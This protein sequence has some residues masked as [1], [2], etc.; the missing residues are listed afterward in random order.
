[1][2]FLGLIAK[3]IGRNLIR[4]ILTALGTMMLVFVVTLV[5]SILS[6]LNVA[7]SEKNANFKA[8]IT[9]RWQI[10]SQMPYTYAATLSEGAATKPDD[11]R[12]M[13]SMT[14]QFYGGSIEKDRAKRGMSNIVFAFSIE[15]KK[16]NTMMDELDNLPPQTA[17]S[18]AKTVK[19]LE[20]NRQGMILGKTRM[21]LLNKKVGDTFTIYSMNYKDIDLEVTVVGEFPDGRYNN[22]GAINKDYLLAAMDAWQRKNGKPHVMAAKSLNLVWLKVPN[23]ATLGQITSQIDGS[24]LFKSPEVKCETAS[25]GIAAFIEPYRD[26]IW[27]MRWLLAPAILVTLSLVISNSISISVRER[28]TELAVLKVLGFRPN[29]ILML[30]LGEAVLI[31]ALSGLIS[32]GLTYGIVNFPQPYGFGGIKFPIA[33]FAAFLIPLDALWWGPALGAGTAFLGSVIPAWS[34]RSVKVSEVFARVA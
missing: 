22:S 28:R 34:A 24:P 18:F 4:S 15:P 9:E 30:V 13:D 20:D 17:A 1:M 29:Q 12:P 31:G 7:L 14:W 27:G 2:K 33:F 26:L 5:W 6:F 23:S 3:N 10:P 32:A 25:S 16:L 8:I 21:E 19:A 11:A